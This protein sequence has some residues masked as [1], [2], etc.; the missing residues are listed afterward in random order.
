[1]TKRLLPMNTQHVLGSIGLFLLLLVVRLA[2]RGDR[3]QE[4]HTRLVSGYMARRAIDFVA[5]VG[6]LFDHAWVVARPAQ[7]N[8]APRAS[9]TAKV[10]A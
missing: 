9:G 8:T 3:P 10:R 4:A 6:W 5:V 2:D 7:P 1:M